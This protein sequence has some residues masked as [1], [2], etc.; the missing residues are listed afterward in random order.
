LQGEDYYVRVFES[1]RARYA[2]DFLLRGSAEPP[3]SLSRNL[4]KDLEVIR[5]RLI[6]CRDTQRYDIWLHSLYNVAR[7]M[8]PLL[9]AS[10]V[11]LLWERL[12]KS[13]C[14]G[15]LDASQ[16]AWLALFK[17][18]GNR[19]GARMAELG[20]R[21]LAQKID[22]P[23]G[24]RQYLLA[25]TLAGHLSLGR[26]LEAAIALKRHSADYKGDDMGLRLLKA[27]AEAGTPKPAP[28]TAATAKAAPGN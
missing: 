3:P 13:P 20:E 16:R 26:R 1:R 8:N 2:L 22:L 23:A 4:Q 28:A 19:D 27:H 11:R 9:P 18:V 10:Q 5:M 17:A 21:L 25:A 12:E 15:T 14:F 6:E 24:H 7:Q